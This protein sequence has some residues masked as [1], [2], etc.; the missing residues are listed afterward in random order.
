MLGQKRC[1]GGWL[2]VCSLII[3]RLFHS[4]SGHH[5][6]ILMFP[7]FVCFPWSLDFAEG[8]GFLIGVIV[9]V[10]YNVYIKATTL[11]SMLKDV[12]DGV[13]E[14][15]QVDELVQLWGAKLTPEEAQDWEQGKRVQAELLRELANLLE[16]QAMEEE[17]SAFA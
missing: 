6:W 7:H 10:S 12:R 14:M 17:G 15:S 11:V 5:I 1:W 8:C 16:A 13:Q 9:S 4:G 2:K 3:G